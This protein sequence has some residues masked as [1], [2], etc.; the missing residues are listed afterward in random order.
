ML[1]MLTTPPVGWPLATHCTVGREP[2][3]HMNWPMPARAISSS[4]A[5][6]LMAL[7]IHLLYV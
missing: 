1:A 4:T 6:M 3:I 7:V 2:S 5:P